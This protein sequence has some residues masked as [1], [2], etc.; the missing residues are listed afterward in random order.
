M[1]ESAIGGIAAVTK[2]IPRLISMNASTGWRATARPADDH[3]FMKRRSHMGRKISTIS[4]P[5]EAT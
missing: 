3:A 2:P 4:P 1:S 5:P